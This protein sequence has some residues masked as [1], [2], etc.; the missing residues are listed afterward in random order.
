M[1]SLSFCV[2]VL[3]IILVCIVIVLI[4]YFWWL[5]SSDLFILELNVVVNVKIN[6]LII[7]YENFGIEVVKL[8]IVK[9]NG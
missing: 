6:V 3:F 9:D 1:C 4:V 5:M 7:F 2:G 8:V